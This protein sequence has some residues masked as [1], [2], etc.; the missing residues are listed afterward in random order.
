MP[1]PTAAAGK[2]TYAYR[3]LTSYYDSLAP[4]WESIRNR[5]YFQGVIRLMRFLAPPGARVLEIGCANGDL[6]AAL[7]P[8]YGVG[9]DLSLPMVEAARGRHPDLHFVQMDAHDLAADPRLAGPFD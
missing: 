6:L 3:D 4:R 2:G 5:Y 1:T 9:V 7:E 8:S